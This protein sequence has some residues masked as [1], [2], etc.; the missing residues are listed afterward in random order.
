MFY[1]NYDI[2]SWNF[3]TPQ[4]SHTFQTSDFVA[5]MDIL[6]SKLEVCL[7]LAYPSTIYKHFSSRMPFNLVPGT[8]WPG[9]RRRSSSRTSCHSSARRRETTRRWSCKT[10]CRWPEVSRPPHPCSS[11]WPWSSGSPRTCRQHWIRIQ[12][13]WCR[14]SVLSRNKYLQGG[15]TTPSIFA[16]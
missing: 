7:P 1:K 10:T 14:I 4:G 12:I 5:R 15:I 2:F 3:L 8:S 9:S 6:R 16:I 11:G 13:D